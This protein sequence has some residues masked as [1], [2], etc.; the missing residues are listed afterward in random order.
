MGHLGRCPLRTVARTGTPP[1]WAAALAGVLA[2]S[3][4]C[5]RTG[6]EGRAVTAQPAVSDATAAA[7]AASARA[8]M[9]QAAAQVDAGRD[10]A[11]DAAP[12]L[13]PLVAA[14]PLIP[15]E[16][17]GHRD[18][19]VSVPLGA[20]SKRPVVVALHGN[21]DRPEWQCDVWRDIT[22]GFP[23]ILCPRG[24]PRTDAPKRYNRWTYR[25]FKT[26]KEELVA[27]LEALRKRFGEYVDQG[28][29]V[30]TGFSLGAILGRYII[31]EQAETFPRVV[32]TEGGYE[33]WDWLARAFKRG[34]GR[35]VLFACGQ[36][37]CVAACKAAARRAERAKLEA[38][39]ADG[40][41]VGHTYDG[42]VA[43]A[44]QAHWDWLVEG[45][46]RWPRAAGVPVSNEPPAR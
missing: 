46:K 28:P 31:K 29:V 11:A 44:I 42:N 20:T 3:C 24:F 30:F 32:F 2:I 18:A 43:A 12:G 16:V 9:G 45:D 33:G 8:A 38:R 36:P 27:G 35:R 21:F 1:R 41:K 7:T 40:G 6:Q 15:L 19:V 26:V 5:A 14:G 4:R 13:P 22:G 34:G 23:F 17:A 25:A 10:G 39:V 37:G